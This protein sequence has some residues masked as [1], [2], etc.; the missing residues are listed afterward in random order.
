MRNGPNATSLFI[1]NPPRI[2]LN[3]DVGVRLATIRFQESDESASSGREIA[4]QIIN[5][6]MIATNPYRGPRSH[7]MPSASFASPSPIHLPRDTSHI[8]NSGSAATVGP[9]KKT[10]KDSSSGT[11]ETYAYSAAS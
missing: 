5:A 1:V 3:T 10:R 4:A 8:K 2:L 9:K 6:S 11:N 7:P